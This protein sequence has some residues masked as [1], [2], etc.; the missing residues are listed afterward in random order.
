MLD[1]KKLEEK[2]DSALANETED[3]LAEWLNSKRNRNVFDSLG[4]GQF[5]S[6]KTIHGQILVSWDSY[7][8][9]NTTENICNVANI[10]FSLAA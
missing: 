6:K 10:R 9:F 1:L 7:S 5:E 3:S 8:L 4:L 2:L